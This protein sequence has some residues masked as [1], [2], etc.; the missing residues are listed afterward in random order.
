MKNNEARLI[1]EEI[2]E[3]FNRLY[4]TDDSN[5]VADY[6][7]VVSQ[8]AKMYCVPESRINRELKKLKI[9]KR[10][11]GIKSVL[12]SMS[13]MERN[14]KIVDMYMAGNEPM[15]I[16]DEVGLTHTRV[17]QIV[18][19]HLG[20]H[21]RN[22]SLEPVLDAIKLDVS[23]GLSHKQILEKY[24]ASALRKIKINLGYNVFEACVNKRNDEIYGIY[25]DSS[26][27]A[28]QIA[29]DYGLTRDHVYGILRKYG[30]RVKPTR[31]EYDE[32]N[33]VIVELFK[34]GKTSQDI[35]YMYNMTVTNVNIILTNTGARRKRKE[36]EG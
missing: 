13:K 3:Q 27:T 9:S 33:R 29:E 4:K 16:A 6:T 25:K 26:K 5:A 31:Q 24:G 17:G 20:K 11:H 35:A 7:Q 8:L 10:T 1:E 22:N 32:R 15:S 2:L 18:R 28:M 12:M 14:S 34:E 21:V 23:N 30:V 36:H 19:E